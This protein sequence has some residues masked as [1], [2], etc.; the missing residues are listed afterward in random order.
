[1]PDLQELCVDV[2]MPDDI[3]QA[4][5]AAGRWT[6]DPSPRAFLRSAATDDQAGGRLPEDTGGISFGEW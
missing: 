5:A 1:M 2:R 3:T 4:L 6:G